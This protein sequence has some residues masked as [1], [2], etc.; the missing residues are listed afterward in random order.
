[1][2]RSKDTA[3]SEEPGSGPGDGGVRAAGAVPGPLQGG[4]SFLRRP[5]AWR[6]LCLVLACSLA[7]SFSPSILSSAG[8]HF[9]LISAVKSKVKEL[10]KKIR[11]RTAPTQLAAVALSST[12]ISLS[13]KDNAKD[14][15]GVGIERKSN[16]SGA[17]IT[18]TIAAPD[19]V[20]YID[21]GLSGDVTYYY[22][23]RAYTP[24]GA[25]D[26]S[27]E[28]SLRTL[29]TPPVISSVT[30][31]AAILS[32][33]TTTSVTC[34]ASDAD[35][36]ALV[37]SWQAA[38][39]TPSG[40]GPVFAWTAPSV[41]GTYKIGCTA[42]DGRGGTDRKDAEVRVATGPVIISITPYP[43]KV[44]SGGT[45]DI[46][47]VAT[48][49][50]SASLTYAWTAASGTPAGTGSSFAWTAP[51]ATGTYLV[52]CVVTDVYGISAFAQ[53][54][55]HVSNLVI[56]ALTA[57]PIAVEPSGVSTITCTA[58]DPDS[59][60]LTYAWLVDDAPYAV[61]PS[62]RIVWTAPA[63]LGTYKITCEAT[64]SA[65]DKAQRDVNVWV[66][67]GPV[68]ISVVAAPSRVKSGAVSDLVC[69]ATA[70]NGIALSYGWTAASGTHAGTGDEFAWTA[71]AATGTYPVYCEVSGGGGTASKSA[72]VQVSNLEITAMTAA[73]GIVY[74]SGVSTITC[75]AEDSASSALTYS[76]VVPDGEYAV[77]DSSRIAWTAPPYVG[78]FTIGCEVSNEA[79]DKAQREAEVLVATG[80]VI[81]SVNASPL[82]VPSGGLSSVVCLATAPGGVALT[83]GWSAASGTHTG[84]GTD[85]DWTAPAATGTYLLYCNVSG[86]GGTASKSVEVQV[87]NL[88]ITS[89]TAVPGVV[90][91]SGVSTITCAAADPDSPV[92]TYDWTVPGSIPYTVL[93]SSRIAWTAPEELG[94]YEIGCKVTNSAGDTAQREV[95]VRVATGPVIISVTAEPGKVMSGRVSSLVCLATAPGG[96][97]LTYAWSA[98][99]G[100]HTG[101]G[102]DF[103]W[104]APAATGT[105]LVYCEASG[106][107]G[108]A[109]KSV[110]VRVINLVINALTAVPGVVEPSGVST[111]T[112]AAAD[113]DSPV[114]DYNWRV[115]A[116]TYELLASSR[117]AWTAPGDLGTYTIGCE[118]TNS[119]GGSAQRDVELRV[120]TGPVIISITSNPLKVPS[121]GKSSI[122]C[123]ATAPGG[124]PL[125]YAWSA[126]SGTHSGSGTDFD[127]TAPAATGTYLVYCNASGGGGADLKSVEVQ[128]SNLAISAL[129]AVP[130]IVYQQ[131]VSTITCAAA[132]PDSPVL[133]YHWQ[134]PAG[135]Y[136]L[137]ASSRIA[138]TAPG[139]LGT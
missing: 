70:P 37:Y 98:A 88:A 138:W 136:E 115:P 104:T 124:V 51:A 119:A 14:E 55:M 121:G 41:P 12:S 61:L 28:A 10:G 125:T 78:A 103:D 38:S 32:T 40:T 134:V 105:Y 133:D 36:D 23:V 20:G 29:N 67:T 19:T 91:Q 123:L 26:Y 71:P 1:M 68:I 126:A 52:N 16:E 30:A 86:G 22:R 72:E 34:E 128:V 82:K 44:T 101:A 33:G 5:G 102:T 50:G 4:R 27:N 90:Y 112:C 89:L 139:D 129:T 47:C 6:T 35:G 43:A 84:A 76:W 135:T 74:K 122:V 117:I 94:T 8:L 15:S 73:P 77:L 81:I 96:V 100:T 3:S 59:P 42:D 45:S 107:G 118:V 7:F 80:P 64:N 13:W 24:A 75:A 11:A 25:S 92:L 57:T 46:V 131:G 137:L 63:D 62:S 132:D 31:A 130:G 56:S 49:P 83:Y 9:G 111:I 99:S 60:V 79:G 85:F 54:E 116:G 114:L 18:L 95:E 93:S 108:T 2:P 58:A 110:E 48:A 65:G 53:V 69:V 87:S 39:G 120:A 17:Y 97:A 127:W 21:T 106:G 109:S 66:A 113:P